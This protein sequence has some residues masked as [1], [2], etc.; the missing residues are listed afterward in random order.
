MHEQTQ[1][2][3]PAVDRIGQVMWIQWLGLRVY[4]HVNMLVGNEVYCYRAVATQLFPALE[5]QYNFHYV[6]M[7][8]SLAHVQHGLPI[9]TEGHGSINVAFCVM[10]PS[11]LVGEYQHVK[12]IYS[13][14]CNIPYP[15]TRLHGITNQKTTSE[16]SKLYE[17]ENAYKRFGERTKNFS[18]SDDAITD[19]NR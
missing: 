15:P 2:A 11:R 5:L 14:F 7:P 19:S 10:T 18:Q 13:T 3:Q 17:V 12:S 4:D 6:T 8:T 9:Q 1:L 16:H